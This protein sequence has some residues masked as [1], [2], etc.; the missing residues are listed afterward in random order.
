MDLRERIIEAVEGGLSRRAVAKRFRT[1]VSCVIKLMQRWKETGTAAPAPMGGHKEFVLA[2]HEGL[3]RRLYERSPTPAAVQHANLRGE[4]CLI[5]ARTGAVSA[6]SFTIRF[7]LHLDVQASL[8]QNGV[9]VLLRLPSGAGWRF[10]CSGGTLQL[11][12]SV[13]CGDEGSRRT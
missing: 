10:Q 9:A 1:S 6:Q 4:D 2:E 8:V 7:H 11:E 12:D 13:Y 3:V 5:P